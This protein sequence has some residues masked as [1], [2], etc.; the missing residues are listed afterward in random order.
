LWVCGRVERTAEAPLM[1]LQWLRTPNIIL[2]ISIQSLLNFAYM[3]GF[4]VVPQMLEIGLGFTPAHIGWLVIARPLTFAIMAPI[5]SFFTMR[6]GERVSGVV[7]AL[8]IVASMM[9]LSTV[10]AGSPDWIIAVA[11]GLSGAGFGIA[12]PALGALVANSVDDETVGVAGAMQQL[13]SQM[14]AVLGSTVMISIHEMTASSGVVQS[15]SYALV[16]GAVTATGATLLAMRLR[17]TDRRDMADQ[18]A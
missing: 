9:M 15:Y 16:S 5:G 17:A 1:P 12:G 4:I 2:P 18:P 6:V 14:G 8:G 13:L 7:G 3:G 11:L 10:G